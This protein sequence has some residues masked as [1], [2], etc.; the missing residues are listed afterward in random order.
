MDP[1]FSSGIGN[2]FNHSVKC[3]TGNGASHSLV[4]PLD[5][6]VTG[7]GLTQAAFTAN[8]L[9]YYFALDIYALGTTR[10]SGAVAAIA[11]NV[12]GHTNVPEPMTLTLFGTGLAAFAA[13]RR[14]RKTAA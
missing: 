12:P 14:R 11:P 3:C 1:P 2:A 13:L 7:A 10:N 8:P 6:D 5:F 4:G 9:G